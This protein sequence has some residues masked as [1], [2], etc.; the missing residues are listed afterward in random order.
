MWNSH[1]EENILVLY[2][3][4]FTWQNVHR[5][6]HF[7][8]SRGVKKR[9]LV[10]SLHIPIAHKRLMLAGLSGMFDQWERRITSVCL[11]TSLT[12]VNLRRIRLWHTGQK[13]KCR[14]ET[15]P[16][17]PDRPLAPEITLSR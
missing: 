5:A 14:Q 1:R 8:P 17:S 13:P 4:N 15:R 2:V 3:D 10:L 6:E 9:V 11:I 12:D 16:D 7:D